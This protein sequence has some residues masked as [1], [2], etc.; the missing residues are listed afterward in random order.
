M[1]IKKDLSLHQRLMN[2]AFGGEVGKLFRGVAVLSSGTVVGRIVGLLSMPLITRLYTPED[3]GIMAVFTAIIMMAAPLLTLRYGVALPLPKNDGIAMNIMAVSVV[4]MIVI[5]TV[6][7]LLLAFFGEPILRLLS[8]E[9]LAPWWWLI[10]LSLLGAG[11][12]ELLS[13][14]ATRKRRYGIIAQTKV[15]QSLAGNG[16]KLCIGLVSPG[17]LGLLLGQF[18]TQSGGIGTLIRAFA[19]DISKSWRYVRWRHMRRVALRHSGFPMFRMPSQLLLVFAQQAPLLFATSMFGASMGGQLG[20]AISALALPVSLIG[21]AVSSAL[22]GEA[23][24]IGMN[25]PKRLLRL[26]EATQARLF[27]MAI[28]PAVVLFFCGE[29][30]FRVIFGPEWETAGHFASLL[31]IYLLFQFTSSPLMQMLNL[32]NAQYVFLAI[33][34]C[35]AAIVLGLVLVASNLN[36]TAHEFIGAYGILMALIYAAMSAWV[37]TTL[38]AAVRKNS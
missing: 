26:V 8:M 33:N 21:G 16:I 23:A 19:T 37:I 36:L 22:Y 35:R 4:I 7:T 28:G 15:I 20:L 32:L 25:N 14:W 10:S 13:F 34:V 29:M 9:A 1:P 27:L 5:L 24:N 30:L 6:S 11:S 17:P 18:A 12:N 38:Q 31:S 2:R 3:F